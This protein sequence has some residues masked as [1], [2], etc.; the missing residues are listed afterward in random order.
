M[1]KWV[2][3]T[4]PKPTQTCPFATPNCYTCLREILRDKSSRTIKLRIYI[5]IYIYFFFFKRGCEMGDLK[6][7]WRSTIKL[8]YSNP[9]DS[10]IAIL[11]VMMKITNSIENF[12]LYSTNFACKLES[13]FTYFLFNFSNSSN[14]IHVYSKLFHVWLLS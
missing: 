7:T 4:Q 5:Y 12:D 3:Y 1:G 6:D 14:S 13:F 8:S 2:L 9:I 10:I 11:Q